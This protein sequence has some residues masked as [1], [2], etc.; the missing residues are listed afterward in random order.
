MGAA[1]DAVRRHLAEVP[2][3]Q[4]AYIYG[5]VLPKI[6]NLGFLIILELNRLGWPNAF[7]GNVR[8]SK[9]SE[10]TKEIALFGI[11]LEGWRIPSVHVGSD[12]VVYTEQI[13]GGVGHSGYDSGGYFLYAK[14]PISDN[15]EL[16]MLEHSPQTARLFGREDA[17]H[18]LERLE[19][20]L[21]ELRSR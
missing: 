3:K 6:V 16:H 17:P 18:I 14:C 10:E 9:T 20:T 12:G 7:I 4:S 8:P 19:E 15:G 2:A 21:Q 13:V 1:E 5:E 11:I